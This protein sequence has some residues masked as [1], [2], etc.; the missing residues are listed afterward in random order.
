MSRD[1][2]GLDTALLS[3]TSRTNLARGRSGRRRRG[4]VI[5]VINAW[6]PRF[7]TVVAS[8]DWHP[9]D[10]VHF[11]TWPPHCVAGTYGAQ[12]RSGLDTGSFLLVL[13]KGTGNVD[14][15]YSAFE[16]TSRGPRKL[17]PRPGHRAAVRL[18]SRDRLLRPA[19]G[20]RRAFARV[21]RHGHP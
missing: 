3:S 15:G 4:R 9:A 14:D 20:A 11:A 17:A 21:R 18:W 6:I 10:S 16:V 5:P 19:D 1:R 7:A 12:F 13:D 2:F 8:R